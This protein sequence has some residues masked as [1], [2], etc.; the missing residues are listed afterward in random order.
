MQAI[1]N[2]HCCN[3]IQYSSSS[4]CIGSRPST[5]TCPWLG[6]D[7]IRISRS[8]RRYNRWRQ[9]CLHYHWSYQRSWLHRHHGLLWPCY[10]L[11]WSL[12]GI[13]IGR[14]CMRS[15]CGRDMDYLGVWGLSRNGSWTLLD[16]RWSRRALLDLLLWN[17]DL[18][19][20]RNCDLSRWC[21]SLPWGDRD[22][23]LTLRY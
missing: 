2:L 7:L 10:H 9:S 13:W 5:A 20:W 6:L 16:G 19:R 22:L 15:V 21:G 18:H 14:P 23:D 3:V 8:F 11:R 17:G 1:F 4:L 12:H